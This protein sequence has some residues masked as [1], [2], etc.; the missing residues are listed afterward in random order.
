MFGGPQV[1]RALV[2]S[3][4]TESGVDIVADLTDTENVPD[5]IAECFIMTQTLPFIFDI[6]GAIRG[7][8]KM[9]K[10]GGYLLVSVPGIT[11]ISRY[12]MD[13]W[14]QYWAFTDKSVSR[15]FRE[16]D[17]VAEILTVTY[18]NVRAASGFLYGLSAAEIGR[19][20]LDRADPDYQVVIGAVIRK[21]S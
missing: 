11:Q 17:T 2:L 5:G 7:A 10:P 14:G 16:I 13:R 15:L 3:V 12:D 1:D 8:L 18:G 21:A 4:Q 20:N 9:V 6:K 19:K